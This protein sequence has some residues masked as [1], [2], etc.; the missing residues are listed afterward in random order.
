MTNRNARAISSAP[1]DR[2][3]RPESLEHRDSRRWPLPPDLWRRF[4]A[5]VT[6]ERSGSITFQV[7]RG[8]VRQMI[9]VDK[10]DPS[11]TV[12]A[13]EDEIS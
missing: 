3:I 13:S 5:F 9:A 8:R 2:M 6:D 4:V 12:A 10:P 7:D 1:E 11:V